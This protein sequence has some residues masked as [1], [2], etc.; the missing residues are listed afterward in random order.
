MDTRELGAFG[1]KMACEYLVEKGCKILGKNWRISFGEIDIIARK[2][3]PFWRFFSRAARPIHF[4]EVKTIVGNNDF[5][6]E[7]RV[8]YKKQQKLRQL[9]QIWL[10]ENNYPQHIPY[11]IDVIGIAIN[12]QTKN[13]KL[14]FF[15]NV[16]E[17]N[18]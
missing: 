11:Q 12:E 2:K 13:A 9:A 8:D 18:N 16:V 10:Q 6:P 5:F 17:D 4:V 15:G 7:E 1:E 14:H 3:L